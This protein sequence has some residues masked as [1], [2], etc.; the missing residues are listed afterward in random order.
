MPLADGY[1]PLAGSDHPHPS[2]HRYVKATDGAEPVTV[3]LMLRRRAGA[4]AKEPKAFLQTSGA[5]PSREE[6]ALTQGA[7]PADVQRV[8]AFAASHGLQI[9]D[10]DTARRSVVVRGPAAAVNAAFSTELKDYDS[11]RG[12]YRGH[13][14][15]VGLP[16]P[17]A[18]VVEAVV[19]LTN[20]QVPAQHFSTARRGNSADPPNT[21][22]VTPQQIAKLYN[23][24]DGDGKGQTIGLYE[25]ETSGGAAGY[26]RSDIEKTMQGFGLPM[27]HIVDVPVDGVKNSG[28]SDGETGLDIT[29]AGAVAPAATIAVYFA[30]GQTQDILHA[31]QMMIHPKAGEPKPSVLSISYG[32]GPDDPGTDSFSDAEYRQL[33]ELFKDAATKNITVLVSSGDSGAFIESK[34]QAQASYPASDIWVTACGGTTV[35]NVSGASFDEYVWNDVGAGGPGATGG[36]ISARF[37]VPDY[38]KAI[39]LPKRTHTG[40]AGRGLPDIAGN[41]SENSGYNQFIGGQSQPVG[42]TSAVAPLYAGLIARINANLGRPAGYLNALLYSLPPAT[43]RDIGGAPGP[44]NNSYGHVTGYPGGAGWDA[45]TGLGSVNGSALQDQLRGQGATQREPAG[46]GAG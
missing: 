40:A 45:C 36:G 29:V 21:R 26:A 39:A 22:P 30:G 34:T 25:M 43:F 16:A 8:E 2:D 14:G 28:V 11:A 24:P 44:A 42:G 35:G 20:R 1:V 6:F 10:T 46:A 31:L 9:V 17:L 3:T 27:P 4:A 19:G 23:F 38:Q 33:T 15:A 37:A 13:D 12:A 18:D 41:A 5:R 7:D 32:W